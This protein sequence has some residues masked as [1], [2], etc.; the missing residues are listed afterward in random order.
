MILPLESG[1][2]AT[3]LQFEEDGGD[4]IAATILPL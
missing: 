3:L 1:P 2:V 4:E